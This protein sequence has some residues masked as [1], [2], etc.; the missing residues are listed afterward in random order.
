MVQD[1]Q[2]GEAL[3]A[4][5]KEMARSAIILAEQLREAMH[6]FSPFAKVIAEVVSNFQKQFGS[7]LLEISSIAH[8]R[9]HFLPCQLP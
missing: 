5:Q 1:P 7:A 8:L 3:K 9:S 6:Q 2:I 4:F